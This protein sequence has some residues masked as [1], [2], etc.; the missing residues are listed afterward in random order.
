MHNPGRGAN[1]SHASSLGTPA[2]DA[3]LIGASVTAHSSPLCDALLQCVE[4]AERSAPEKIILVLDV[5]TLGV[6]PM[7]QPKVN[8]ENEEPQHQPCRLC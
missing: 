3:E 6:W 4:I 2:H 7:V 5:D 1:S 8:S